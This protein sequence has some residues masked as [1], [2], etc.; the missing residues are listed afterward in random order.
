MIPY[1]HALF[2]QRHDMISVLMI[3]GQNN[4]WSFESGRFTQVLLMLTRMK[5]VKLVFLAKW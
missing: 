5:N 4:V 2:I 3:Y 1:F